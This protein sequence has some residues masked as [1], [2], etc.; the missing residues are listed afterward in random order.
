MEPQRTSSSPVGG[1]APP[2]LRS[3]D[4]S[5][6]S[7]DRSALE[8]DGSAL[9]SDGS[10]LESDRELVL[11]RVFAAPR[12]LVFAAWTR[13]EHFARWF[14]PEGFTMPVCEMDARAGGAIR[15][16]MGPSGSEYWH[17][18][19]FLEVEAPARIVFT[20]RFTDGRG[21]P[22]PHPFFPDWPVD[23]Q[24]VQTV[25][26]TERRGETE[27]R[28]Y[29]VV[30]PPEAASHPAFTVERPQALEGWG[31]SFGRLD[32]LLEHLAQTAG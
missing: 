19:E 28:V 31:E 6:P 29:Q 3:E 8:S 4:R 14:G 7:V 9:E 23:A 30:T 17:E 12:E 5:A 25:T 32:A 20:L 13:A 16:C 21:T 2:M 18:G 15:F 22:V 27:V 1:D 26:F 24:F 10:T 11:T